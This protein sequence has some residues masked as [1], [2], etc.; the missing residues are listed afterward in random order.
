MNRIKVIDIHTKKL[1]L[2]SLLLIGS[3]LLYMINGSFFLSIVNFNIIFHLGIKL[4]HL[5]WFLLMLEML[6]VLIP[7][8]NRYVSCGKC[9]EHHHLPAEKYDQHQVI[10]HIRIYN[11]RARLTFVLWMSFII[12]IALLYTF[13][14]LTTMQ[15]ILFVVFLY[16]LDHVFITV[17]CPIK[18][19]L[20]KNKCC[21][22]CRIYNW[23]HAMMFSPLI[24]IPS[25][26]TYTLILLAVIILLYWEYSVYKYPERFLEIANKNLQCSYCEMK[27]YKN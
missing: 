5:I 26:W 8:L 23:G 6:F 19:F 12:V 11:K 20:I 9:F 27:C 25:F 18:A 10:N 16:F 17:W 24:V 14:L 21:T 3:I 1:I 7:S 13:K 4:Y 2:R 15:I 22:S